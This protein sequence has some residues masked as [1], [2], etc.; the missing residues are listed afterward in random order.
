MKKLVF[1]CGARDF[2]AIDW[3][4]SSLE[5]LP[6]ENVSILTDLIS[7]EGFKKIVTEKDTIHS[8]LI[9]DKFLFKGQSYLGNLWRNILKL[10]VL[11]TQIIL[12]KRFAKKNPNSTYHAHSMYYLWLAAGAGVE[13]IGTPQGSDLLVKPFRSKIYKTL[14]IWAMRAAKNITVDSV[15]MRDKAFEIANITPE[16]I[17]NGIDV[18]SI[19]VFLNSQSNNQ[20][21]RNKL[22]SIR[23]MTPLYRIEEIL[24]A[25][26]YSNKSKD[27]PIS[28]IYPFYEKEYKKKVIKSLSINDKDIGR[29][30]RIKMYELLLESKLVFSIP[31]SDSSPRSVYES[32]FCGAI[33]AITY[34]SYYDDLP[35]CMKNRIILIDLQDKNWFIK[36]LNKAKSI[37]NCKFTPSE[38]ALDLFDQRRCFNRILNLLKA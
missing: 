3:Y 23:G 38:Q 1:L 15:K 22:L 34:Q 12:L 9:L 2:H 8:L 21:V 35:D 16:I 28:L 26:D 37:E 29:V 30:E 33:V 18:K 31:S 20:I 27:F 14:S 10:L 24:S 7:G 13:F 6:K 36:V 17:Q 4:R 32:I 25:R 5:Q 19:E 11:P